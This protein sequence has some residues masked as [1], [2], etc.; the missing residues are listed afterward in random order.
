MSISENKIIIERYFEEVWNKGKLEVL[1]EI[2]HQNYINHSPGFPNSAKGP[3]GLKPIVT[4][5]RIG[6][7]DL[8]FK[9]DD[10]IITDQ[11]VAIRSTMSGT[12]LGDLFGIAATGKRVEVNQFQIEYILGGKIIE[13]WRQS[14]DFGMMKQLGQIG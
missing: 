8:N 14:D 1:D 10:L 5:M 4:A 9:V 2:I 12:H 11:K 13:H 7:P 3:A 6:F